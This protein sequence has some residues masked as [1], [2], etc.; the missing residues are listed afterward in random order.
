M[1]TQKTITG[2]TIAGK[3]ETTGKGRHTSPFYWMEAENNPVFDFIMID[4]V[5]RKLVFLA[6][7]RIHW[8][9]DTHSNAD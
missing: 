8:S 9:G 3:I 5:T 7:M 1:E 2:E 4:S 6:P